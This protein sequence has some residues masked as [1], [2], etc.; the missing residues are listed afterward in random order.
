MMDRLENWAVLMLGGLGERLGSLTR[1]CPKPLLKV[2][3]KPILETILEQLIDFGFYRFY[4]IVNYKAKMIKDYFGDGSKW[5]ITIHY[6]QEKKKMGTAGG[7]KLISEK[8]SH[9]VFVMNG[10][11]LTTLNFRKLLKF[12][13]EMKA[14][15]TMCV[16]Q[17]EIEIPYGVVQVKNQLLVDIV[18]K[19]FHQIFVSTGIY[20]LE[21]NVLDCIPENSFYDMPN[22]FQ[23]LIAK[24][25]NVAAFPLQEEYWVDIGKLDDLNR[26]NAEFNEVFK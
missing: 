13:A 17:C 24:N 14:Q 15:A 12:H 8:L 2:G 11:L 4:F 9:P 5:G 26:A 10:D 16:R 20:V 19:P 3:N 1:D 23:T 21:P 25:N 7:L 18:E 6:L 22:L